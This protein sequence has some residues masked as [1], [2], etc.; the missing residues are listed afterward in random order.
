[1][2]E[3]GKIPLPSENERKSLFERAEN[4]FGF[5]PAPVPAEPCLAA[6]DDGGAF[7]LEIAPEGDAR[8]ERDIAMTGEERAIEARVAGER[9]GAARGLRASG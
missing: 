9:P 1:M 7:A 2:T 5:A 6:A 4:L 3:Q 8:C